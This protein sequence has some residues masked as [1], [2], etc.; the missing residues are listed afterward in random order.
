MDRNRDDFANDS[1]INTNFSKSSDGLRPNS[2]KFNINDD[3]VDCDTNDKKV[4]L[5]FQIN[6]SNKLSLKIKKIEILNVI[7]KLK[8]VNKKAKNIM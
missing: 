4:I 3:D 7:K 6:L 5:V 2:D 8:S 1:L